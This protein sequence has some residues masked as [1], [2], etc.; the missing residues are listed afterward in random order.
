MYISDWEANLE[1]CCHKYDKIEKILSL[2]V[3]WLN[4][5]HCLKLF[6]VFQVHPPPARV[7]HQRRAQV[8]PLGQQQIQ[9]QLWELHCGGVSQQVRLIVYSAENNEWSVERLKHKYQHNGWPSSCSS[10]SLVSATVEPAIVLTPGQDSWQVFV[11]ELSPVQFSYLP[12]VA[13]LNAI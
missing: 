2:S 11:F 7:L 10:F 8:Q 1:K 6:L 9:I 5:N 3:L 4:I 13:T 12:T